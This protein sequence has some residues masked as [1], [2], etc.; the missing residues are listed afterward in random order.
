VTNEALVLLAAR[1]RREASD[2]IVDFRG[3]DLEE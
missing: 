1:D 2:E 3:I